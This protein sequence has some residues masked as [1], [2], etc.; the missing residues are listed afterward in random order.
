[1]D[2]FLRLLATDL[3]FFRAIDDLPGY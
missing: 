3:R 1:L 2:F